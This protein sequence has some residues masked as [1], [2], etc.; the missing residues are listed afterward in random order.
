[1]IAWKVPLC[2]TPLFLRFYL[3][4]SS[5]LSLNA[6]SLCV[7]PLIYMVFLILRDYFSL[8]PFTFDFLLQYVLS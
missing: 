8:E 2:L 4:A 1:M 6:L 7:Q 5:L 3:V